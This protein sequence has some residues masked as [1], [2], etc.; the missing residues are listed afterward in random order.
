MNFKDDIILITGSNGRIGYA[1]DSIMS[2]DLICM[3]LSRRRSIACALRWIFRLRTVCMTVCAYCA[4]IMV[5][6][7]QLWYIWQ[8]IMIFWVSPATNM[9]PSPL[10]VRV[11]C[12]K[13]CEQIFRL[14]S[15][16]FPAQSMFD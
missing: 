6:E 7:L 8:R 14:D 4:S 5:T 12:C 13:V 15:S 1:Q 11:A 3:P 2:S 10:R 16:F 9:T